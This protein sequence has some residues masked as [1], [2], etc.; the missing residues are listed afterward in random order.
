ML[1]GIE[2]DLR[3]RY[4]TQI[5]VNGSKAEAISLNPPVKSESDQVDGSDG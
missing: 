5:E 4:A 3:A 1:T 2:Q